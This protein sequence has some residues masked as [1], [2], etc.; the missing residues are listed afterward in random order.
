[1][2][3]LL[4]LWLS[5]LG[6]ERVVVSGIAISLANFCPVCSGMYLKVSGTV[7][8]CCGREI[9]HPCS[10]V[11]DQQYDVEWCESCVLRESLTNFLSCNE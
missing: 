4:E 11:E 6:F 7:C 2:F 8:E 1:M 5:T 9:C 3:K 10:V